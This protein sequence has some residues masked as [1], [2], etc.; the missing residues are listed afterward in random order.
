MQ[1]ACAHCGQVLEFLGKRPSFCGYCGKSLPDDTPRST[2]EF[3]HEAV[4]RAP[5]PADAGADADP[6]EVGGY[7]LL[8]VLGEGGM[9]KV[10]EAQDL[11]TGRHVAL[12]L[13]AAQYAGSPDAVERFRREGRLASALAHPRCVFVL[14]ADEE[15]GRP[16]IVME[17]M[18]GD[19]LEDLLCKQGPL[20]PEQALPKILDV[21]EGLQEA[22]RLGVVHRDV[23]PSNCFVEP[24][25]RVKV[26]DFGLAK[27]LVSGAHLTK[28]GSFLG[29]VQ[30][31][32]PEQIKGEPTGPHSD[33]YSVAATFYC[34]LT[35]KAPF[36]G[37]DPA[38]TLARIVCDPAP[39]MRALRPEL[40]EALDQV[41]LRGLER[42]CDRRWRNLEEFEAALRPFLPG[43]L[44]IVGLGVRFGAYVIDFFLLGLLGSAIS[45]P[46]TL[47][48]GDQTLLVQLVDLLTWLV[49]FAV[50][51]AF[52]GWSLGKRW[53]GLRV[54][55]S[56]G[57]ERPGLWRSLLRAGVCYGLLDL[58]WIGTWLLEFF[59]ALD[60]SPSE[61]PITD[62]W[63]SL[64]LG[65][66]YLSIEAAGIMLVVCSMRTRNGYRGLHEWA[67][68]TRVIRLP[69][70]EARR[71]LGSGCNELSVS[72]PA[73]LPD[74]V[75]GLRVLGAVRADGPNT[76]LLGED[77][78]LGRK[79][80]LWLRP[81]AIGTLVS[82]KRRG[83]S[84]V[85]RPRW[86]AGGRHD[87]QLWDAF[88]APAGHPLPDVVATDGRLSWTETRHLLT[89]LTE[90]L[91]AGT[92]DSTLPSALTVEQIWVQADGRLQLADVPLIQDKPG[93]ALRLLR[94]VATLAL[95]GR[96]RPPD[97]PP[98]AIRTPLPRHAAGML[99]RLTGAG[100][101]YR[102]IQQFHK[103]L[104]DTANKPTAVTRSRRLAHV[105]V[106]AAF[107]S[108]GLCAGLAPAGLFPT[109]LVVRGATS[110]LDSYELVQ[111]GLDTLAVRDVAAALQHDLIARCLAL[112]QLQEDLRLREQLHAATEQKRHF[113]D[114]RR[115]SLS[116]V[117]Q[118]LAASW[119]ETQADQTRELDRSSFSRSLS[120]SDDVR[121]HNMRFYAR[122][123]SE[124][125]EVMEPVNN[126]T[127]TVI[128]L[129]FLAW[130][131]G[132][133]VWAFLWRGGFS[134]PLLGL[135]LVR[136]DGRPAGR[137]QCAW[138]AYLFWAP[139]AVLITCSVWL[140][141][142]YWSA[143]TPEGSP[144]WLAWL[145]SV[146]WWAG[147]ALLPAYL[148]PALWSPER[149]L[150]DRLAGTY[151]VPR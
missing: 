20:P 132:W 113:Y 116:W 73:G 80:L 59:G 90:E 97:S 79:A 1:L 50:P 108:F 71:S 30:Y 8:R 87:D 141:T 5:E 142:K 100:E 126:P 70:A 32:S 10:Y 144:L 85:T 120:E 29:T 12:K 22:H 67:S 25:G 104:A 138:R 133:V 150:H 56:A 53:L 136:R 139:V 17:L 23:K 61:D 151:L 72:H 31:A 55:R 65:V 15:A 11:A 111:E 68:G 74:R 38:A 105:G 69:E 51:E 95:E 43:K 7:R 119:E 106:L 148:I 45:L 117:S 57:A 26:G 122:W 131:V 34:L 149:S 143:W 124:Q 18:P 27:S 47:L 88:L 40:P 62:I 39:S 14:A 21:I 44:S 89:Q 135:A 99:D 110:N 86:L 48:G 3:D 107:L 127:A 37:G 91:T 76:V 137:P 35:G 129:T 118:K 28:T 145:A 66:I 109:I 123:M 60:Y 130:P 41:V 114:A 36:H 115:R 33:V 24:D 75:G 103:D 102:D 4:T 63:N 93:D 81:S 112:R 6:T 13:I 84:R 134:Y 52:W 83:V 19:T 121:S 46:I 16:Y 94:D 49:Y 98:S 9:G 92:A 77:A 101:P 125:P 146:L 128:T 2:V 147:L 140:S 64:L 96:S 54:V 42:D 78:A 82:D 58:G